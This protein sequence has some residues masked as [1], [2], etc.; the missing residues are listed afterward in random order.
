MEIYF[1]NISDI[2]YLPELIPTV[3]SG[4]IRTNKEATQGRLIYVVLRT[5]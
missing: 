3:P 4:L 1:K 5:P 2:T